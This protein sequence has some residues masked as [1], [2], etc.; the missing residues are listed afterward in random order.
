MRI[1]IKKLDRYYKNVS[2]SNLIQSTR[3]LIFTHC[4][5]PMET[6]GRYFA[7]M[8]YCAGGTGILL[9]Y[10]QKF[11]ILTAQHVIDANYKDPQNESP[12][13][14]PLLSNKSL[15]GHNIEEIGFPMRGWRIGE[16]IPENNYTGERDD[17]VLIELSGF[18]MIH[19]DRYI[20]F[21]K[22]S[23]PKGVNPKLLTNGLFLVSSGYPIDKNPI[24]YLDNSE[25]NCVTTLHRHI[26]PGKCEII[27]GQ[28][29]LRLENKLSHAEINGMSGGLVSN[30][31]E[32]ANKT[33]W[34]GL[35]QR[36][37][38]GMIRFFPAFYII[39]AI[40]RYTKSSYYIIDP[41]AELSNLEVE[42]SPDAIFARKE[43]L[44]M[45]KKR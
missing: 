14:T 37:G 36:G 26:L 2:R 32:K 20:D 18:I 16:L 28:P 29:I 31:S 34:V 21:D 39:P 23:H 38:E 24:E 4:S 19:P 35:I 43:L 11:F 6:T 1:T 17:L 10:Q 33:E 7:D 3:R 15:N 45:A 42:N 25:Y 44:E 12:F 30:I 13:F 41:A 40:K 8:I 27:E 5:I 22:V 9:K